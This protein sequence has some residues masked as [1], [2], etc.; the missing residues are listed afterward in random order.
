MV[1]NV[2]G[3]QLLIYVIDT[4]NIKIDVII[5]IKTELKL[6]PSIDLSLFII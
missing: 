5:E 6:R 3:F 4:S 1:L 2:L